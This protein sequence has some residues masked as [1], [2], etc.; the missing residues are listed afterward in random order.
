M[1]APEPESPPEPPKKTQ[2]SHQTNVRVETPL[3]AALSGEEPPYVPPQFDAARALQHPQFEL[4]DQILSQKSLLRFIKR[5]RPKYDAGWVH[6]DICRR[7]E[8]FMQQVERGE[9]PRLL[10]MMP[11]RSGKSEIG[12]RHFPAWA[13]GHHPD[14]EIIA[15]SHTAGLTM[16]FSRY[17][18]D[19]LNDPAYQSVFPNTRLDPQSKSVENWNLTG[20]GG[21]LAAGVGT[22]ITGR[23]AHC[24]CS[25]TLLQTQYGAV[26][27][28]H[29]TTKHRVLSYDHKKQ[30][31]T[32]C[33]VKATQVSSR[34]DIVEIVTD[35]GRRIRSTGDHPIY[36]VGKGYT[37]AGLLDVGDTLTVARMPAVWSAEASGVQGVS[38][39]LRAGEVRAGELALCELRQ[40][41]SEEGVGAREGC[42]ERFEGKLLFPELQRT[43][44]RNKECKKV[45]SVR[46]SG[47]RQWAVEKCKVLFASMS[48]GGSPGKVA[49]V[50]GVPNRI[51]VQ[52][53][54]L[55]DLLK[56]MW[57]ET[58]F[59][60]NDGGRKFSFQRW[61]ELQPMVFESP[62]ACFEQGPAVCGLRNL[63]ESPGSSFERDTCGQSSGELGD[64]MQDL[65]C[66]APQIGTD[67]VSVVRKIHEGCVPVYDIQVAETSNFFAGE[68]LAHNCLILD[69]LVKDLQ[70]ADSTTITETTWEWYASTA[71]TRLAPGGGVL[72]IMTWWSE[73]D[74]AGRIQSTMETGE[75]DVFEVVKY[76]A[77]NEEGDEYLLVDT[78]G[79]PV[80]QIAPGSDIPANAR[81]TRP[82]NTAIHP[83][84]Y[85]TAAMLRIKKNLIATGQKR[86]WQAL[87]QQNPVPDD[88][89]FFTKEMF[90][91]CPALPRRSACNVY[92]AWDFAISTTNESDYT[93]GSTI[94]QD[95]HDS[96]YVADVRRFRS[97]DAIYIIDTILDYALEHMHA[98]NLPLLGFEDGQIWKAMQAQFDKRCAERGIYPSYEILKPLTDK[99]VRAHP[100]RGRMQAGKIWF[101]DKAH[102]LTTLYN[103]M[104]RFPAAKHDDQIDSLAW[105]VRLTLGRHAPKPQQPKNK[106][107]SWKDKLPGLARGSR[108]TSHMAS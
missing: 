105:N 39:M 6:E 86:V 5:F 35:Q 25:G 76:P 55:G 58:S 29:I 89:L 1:P 21:Y 102:W 87:Y 85:N 106:L 108:G 36:I 97:S 48:K 7:L 23:G 33:R 11:P 43:S 88:G 47:L 30:K 78:P 41:F 26:K 37:E 22:G 61:F 10:L 80:V 93:V 71:Y 92:Q 107:K 50:P 59:P 13:L 62:A 45:H 18:R 99:M 73:T 70:S 19:L 42:A 44:P 72:G 90:R 103:E 16:S 53:Q 67:T 101:L 77:V 84:R 46:W 27:I 28:E 17:N 40:K 20:T 14:W 34:S 56:G 66:S 91:Y 82:Q 49:D 68:I 104:V 12:S 100:L 4:A 52:K 98:K 32:Y 8:R 15:A 2:H 75:G 83:A 57:W 3:T 74:W 38:K 96:L 81:L 94:Y 31:L 79:E 24:F 60:A 51:Q 69:D 63:S 54:T 64:V 95:E 9:S 65:P